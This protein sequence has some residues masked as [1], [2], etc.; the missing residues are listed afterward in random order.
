MGA[1]VQT[2]MCSI[3]GSTPY[4]Q[5]FINIRMSSINQLSKSIYKGFLLSPQILIF[6]K[7]NWARGYTRMLKRHRTLR[8]QLPFTCPTNPIHEHILL[9]TPVRLSNLIAPFQ[10]L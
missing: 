3:P 4:G 1:F 8:Y 6:E 7:V 10:V 5:S 9:H 2:T